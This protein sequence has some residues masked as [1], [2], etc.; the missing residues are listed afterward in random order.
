MAIAYDNYS[1]IGQSVTGDRSWSHTCGSGTN[2]YLVVHIMAE[3]GGGGG[4]PATPNGV[5]Y[6]GVSMTLINSRIYVTSSLTVYTYGLA[7]P[8]SGTNTVAVDL[9]NSTLNWSA[10][11]VSYTGVK[12]TGT[13]GATSTSQT[14]TG[15]ESTV[16]DTITTTTDN[17]WVIATAYSGR[18]MSANS[19]ITDRETGAT[20]EYSFMGDTNGVVSPAGDHTVTLNLL[21]SAGSAVIALTE[22]LAHV[23]VTR[24]VFNIS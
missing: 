6:N 24:R 7:N 21:T 23:E 9:N 8:A 18:K 22:I 14:T 12:Q 19:G 5:T 4:N 10:G 13:V 3:E 2:R 1:A 20:L 11:A 16:F 15:S 17:S